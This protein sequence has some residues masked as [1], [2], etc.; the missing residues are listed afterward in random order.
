MTF[1]RLKKKV[2]Q[3]PLTRQAALT[4]ETRAR[5]LVI[6]RLIGVRVAAFVCLFGGIYFVCIIH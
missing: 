5:A 1:K 6:T 2:L 3:L 4:A